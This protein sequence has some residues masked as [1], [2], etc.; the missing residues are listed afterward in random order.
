MPPFDP[1][2]R[3]DASLDLHDPL[4]D[5]RRRLAAR[6]LFPG[7]CNDLEGRVDGQG[8]SRTLLATSARVF[9]LHA[10]R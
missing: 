10:V 5:A 4:S 6:H 8:H 3:T 7:H 2:R 1:L 9:L